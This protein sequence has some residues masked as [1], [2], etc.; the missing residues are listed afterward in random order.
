MIERKLNERE[1]SHVEKGKVRREN[2]RGRQ[3]IGRQGEIDK[4][5][6]EREG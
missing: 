2:E 6:R 5:E 1:R 3:K 4:I